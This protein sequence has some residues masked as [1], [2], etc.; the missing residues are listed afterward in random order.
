[1]VVFAAA[2]VF[3]YLLFRSK[4]QALPGLDELTATDEDSGN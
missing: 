1:M 3:G 4:R 2:P